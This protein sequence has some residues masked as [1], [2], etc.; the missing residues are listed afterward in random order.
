MIRYDEREMTKF[1]K[2]KIMVVSCWKS[3]LHSIDSI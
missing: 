1:G 3:F 2:K